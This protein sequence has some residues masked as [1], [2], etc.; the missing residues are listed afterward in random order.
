M[1]DLMLEFG[2]IRSKPINYMTW[3][4]SGESSIFW[5]LVLV[6]S[7]KISK[8]ESNDNSLL[9]SKTKWTFANILIKCN[10]TTPHP[11]PHLNYPI[12]IFVF[13]KIVKFVWAKKNNEQNNLMIELMWNNCESIWSVNWLLFF[14]QSNTH[15]NQQFFSPF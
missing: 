2:Q 3:L 11:H 13:G 12:Q 5:N 15:L 1:C 6:K 9:S 10:F 8:K 4:K 14:T 7:M